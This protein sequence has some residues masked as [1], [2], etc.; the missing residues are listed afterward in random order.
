MEPTKSGWLQVDQVCLKPRFEPVAQDMVYFWF[1]E[2]HFWK[3][4]SFCTAQKYL[5]KNTFLIDFWSQN[6][7]FSRHIVTLQWPN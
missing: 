1:G 5:W 3:K 6:N 7:P 4:S 2:A